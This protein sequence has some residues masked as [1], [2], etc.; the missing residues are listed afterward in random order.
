MERGKTFLN[1]NMWARSRCPGDSQEKNHPLIQTRHAKNEIFIMIHRHTSVVCVLYFNWTECWACPPSM[2]NVPINKN[3]CVC[4]S[5]REKKLVDCLDVAVWLIVLCQL[6]L[7]SF[8]LPSRDK[9][10]C[11][12]LIISSVLRTLHAGC[13]L[14]CKSFAQRKIELCFYTECEYNTV[15]QLFLGRMMLTASATMADKIVICVSQRLVFSNHQS[16]GLVR[17]VATLLSHM[18]HWHLQMSLKLSERHPKIH[19]EPT[20]EH[21]GTTLWRG[22]TLH[23]LSEGVHPKP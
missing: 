22:E 9:S 7:K 2:L 5:L 4:V 23:T 13:V 18:R 20:L 14:S 11:V 19:Q 17:A 6:W 21:L 12:R 3:L 10:V 15:K 16:V 8:S 1:A